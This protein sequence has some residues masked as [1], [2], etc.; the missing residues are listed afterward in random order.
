LDQQLLS[1][2]ASGDTTAFAQFYDRHAARVLDALVRWL[3]H[4]GDA[5][6]V[7]QEIFW[8][9]W[10]RA[11]KYDAGRATPEVWLFMIARSRA[12]D[13][14]RRRRPE[15][16]PSPG[17]EPVTMNDPF[18]VLEGN[19]SIHQLREA[20]AKLPEEQRSAISLAF[21]GGLTYEQVARSQAIPVG[22][23]KTRIRTGIKRL[24]E[25]LS[26][27]EGVKAS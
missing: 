21:Y 11:D 17:P 1:R 9:V 12:L 22:T 26:G 23:A 15:H 6:D 20:L 18:T 7:L 27:E 8:Q 14:L 24:R 3:R 4:R 25:L 10:C 5:E 13:Y 16:L 19:E 2:M